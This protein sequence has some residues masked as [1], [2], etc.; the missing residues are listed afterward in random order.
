MKA[1]ICDRCRKRKDG[2]SACL[3]FSSS[4]MYLE[5]RDYPYSVYEIDLCE[6]CWNEFQKWINEKV[7]PSM[8][9]PI[10]RGK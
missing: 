2:Y 3:E 4:D 1:F 9:R 7:P 10:K 5:L 6:D 8:S